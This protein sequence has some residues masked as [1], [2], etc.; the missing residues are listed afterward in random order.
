[1]I[2]VVNLLVVTHGDFAKGIAHS[3]KMIMGESKVQYIS[4][5]EDM[6]K[7]ELTEVMGKTLQDSGP[8]NQYLIFCDMMGGTPFN[9]ASEFSFKNPNIAVFYGLN[10][11]LLVEG[12][13]NADQ[14]NLDELSSYLESVKSDSIG[15]SQI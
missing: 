8:E 3:V 13:A 9:T 4:L 11:P 15:L 12:I 10:L 14:K 7:E 2:T 6:G 1:M 5:E